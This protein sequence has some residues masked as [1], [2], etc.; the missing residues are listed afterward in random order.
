[1][2]CLSFACILKWLQLKN[3]YVIIIITDIYLFIAEKV[4]TQQ[5]E[6]DRV[7]GLHARL[8]HEADKIRKWKVQTELELKGKV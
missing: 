1:M 8:S 6:E 7:K 4:E 3:I 2:Y 5:T